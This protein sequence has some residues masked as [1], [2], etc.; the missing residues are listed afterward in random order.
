MRSISGCSSHHREQFVSTFGAA[1]GAAIFDRG[2]AVD[3]DGNIYMVDALFDNVRY[4]TGKGVADVLRKTGATGEFWLPSGIFIDSKDT[5]YISDSYNKRV[6][7]FQYLKE[8]A[9]Q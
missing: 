3:S 7:I 9:P 1:G 2:V 8:G 4:S 6:Q 5:I